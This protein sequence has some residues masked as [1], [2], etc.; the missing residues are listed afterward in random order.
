MKGT[1]L[2]LMESTVTE[3]CQRAGEDYHAPLLCVQCSMG[4][5][6][7]VCVHV[8]LKTCTIIHQKPATMLS[9]LLYYG[10]NTAMS[11]SYTI[12]IIYVC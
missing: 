9:F 1:C 11:L 7:V 2:N 3:V 5:L 12:I 8:S 6:I 10:I 4:G